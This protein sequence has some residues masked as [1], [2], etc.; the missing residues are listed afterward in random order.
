[1]IISEGDFSRYGF[2]TVS[3]FYMRRAPS[4]GI[5]A[6]STLDVNLKVAQFLRDRRLSRTREC[7]QSYILDP[8]FSVLHCWKTNGS[9]CSIPIRPKLRT[10]K[11]SSRLPKQAIHH[12]VHLLACKSGPSLRAELPR[13]EAKAD[14]DMSLI[15]DC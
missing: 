4:K 10:G 2:P 3:R 1:M 9:D 6:R 13:V 5:H 11:A 12:S 8:A 15:D 7:R 14:L